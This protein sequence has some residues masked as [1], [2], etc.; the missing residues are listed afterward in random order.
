M[1]GPGSSSVWETCLLWQLR[2]TAHFL[3]RLYRSKFGLVRFL[4]QL[5]EPGNV[6]ENIRCSPLRLGNAIQIVAIHATI[7]SFPSIHV[8]IWLDIDGISKLYHVSSGSLGTANSDLSGISIYVPAGSEIAMVYWSHNLGNN[9][10][11]FHAS[12][13]IFYVNS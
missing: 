12:I 1:W 13:S 3:S 8:Q 10:G 7:S 5:W 9:E 2:S 11:D 4:P 6:L